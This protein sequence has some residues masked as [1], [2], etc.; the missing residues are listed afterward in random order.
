MAATYPTYDAA[1]F[2]FGVKFNHLLMAAFPTY[3]AGRFVFEGLVQDFLEHPTVE[4]GEFV[5]SGL[6]QDARYAL[7]GFAMDK[8]VAK[9][10]GRGRHNN[11]HHRR[12]HDWDDWSDDEEEDEER[13]M[14]EDIFGKPDS[15][16]KGR[17]S[18][19]NQD[20]ERDKQA[21]WDWNWNWDNDDWNQEK[22]HEWKLSDVFG[23]KTEQVRPY[24]YLARE[25]VIDAAEAKALPQMIFWMK[26]SHFLNQ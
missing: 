9:H 23:D 1:K 2:H 14:W 3:D 22:K 13:D 10:G 20:D 16:K 26:S 7:A 5:L 15:E 11:R 17:K 19:W 24:L 12:S 21:D 18:W 8:L 25:M 6:M 4:A